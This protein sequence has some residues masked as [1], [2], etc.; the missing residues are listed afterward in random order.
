MC[1]IGGLSSCSNPF[2]ETSELH[3]IVYVSQPLQCPLL[4]QYRPHEV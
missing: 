2:S 1:T 3:N 4:A